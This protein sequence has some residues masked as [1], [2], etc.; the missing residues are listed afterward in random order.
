MNQVLANI[1]YFV[2]TIFIFS[3]L[4]R[5]MGVLWNTYVPWNVKTD[6][7]TIFVVT[8]ILIVVSFILSSLSFKVIRSSN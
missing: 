7:L 1:I 3:T 6:L 8:P 2:F 5:F 4:W